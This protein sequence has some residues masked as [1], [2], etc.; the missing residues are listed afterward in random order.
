MHVASTAWMARVIL[1]RL[2]KK[3]SCHAERARRRLHCWW[4]KPPVINVQIG[5]SHRIR[6]MGLGPNTTVVL[7]PLDRGRSSKSTT[8]SRRWH[9]LRSE[10]EK[11][12]IRNAGQKLPA[13]RL[14]G[15]RAVTDSETYHESRPLGRALSL[16]F[17]ALFF[18]R[19]ATRFTQHYNTYTRQYAAASPVVAMA[20]HK[21]KTVIEAYETRPP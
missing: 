9:V 2:R 3:S 8:A 12:K 16:T 7:L 19:A 18:R 21:R 10:A 13:Y 20:R 4:S 14:S 6:R 15:A 17:R 11:N 5:S 1:P